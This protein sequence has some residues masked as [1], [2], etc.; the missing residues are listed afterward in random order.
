MSA[1]SLCF[2]E[3]RNARISGGI[4]LEECL[5]H[6]VA[7][8]GGLRH[9][10]DAEGQRPYIPSGFEDEV[11][12]L[13]L[14]E[15]IQ[16][17]DDDSVATIHSIFL[18]GFQ[19]DVA[20]VRK[21][22]DSFSMNSE[23]YLRPLMRISTEKGDAQLLRVCFENGFSGTSYL[24]SEHLL[25][26]RVHSNPTT[27]WLDVLFEFD[28]RQW[29]TDPQQL[30]QWRTWHH[31]LYMGAECT[32]WWIEHGGRTP[33]VRGL[34]EHARGWPGAPTVRVLLDQFGV[35]W[36]NDSGTLQLA[37][38]NHD[39]E[40][41]KMLVE[42]GADVNEDVTDWQMDVREHRAAP[43][44]AL[45]MAVFAKSEKMIRYLAEHG[46]KLERKYVYIPDPYNQ[47]PKEYRVFVDLVVELGAVKE[48]TSL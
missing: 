43:L 44:S 37:V 17:L 33:R 39:F 22:I 14:S 27:A 46:A 15:D 10:A 47:L 45:H 2:E 25:R 3:A 8:Y 41:V 36:F 7:H 23:Y 30:G 5:R 38:K 6:I 12:N 18:S 29:R 16:P 34:F 42:A 48:E 4:Q 32:R 40:T 11:R 24:D 31:V 9:E 1:N 35:D 13:L 28:F 20:A 26:S 21:L 19:G